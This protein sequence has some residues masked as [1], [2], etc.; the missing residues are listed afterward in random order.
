[1]RGD[2]LEEMTMKTLADFKRR[3]QV[4]TRLLCVAN[5]Y[6]PNVNGTVREVIEARTVGFISK[7]DGCDRFSTK[8]PKANDFRV[9]DADTVEWKLFPDDDGTVTLRFVGADAVG[10]PYKMAERVEPAPVPAHAAKHT[11]GPWEA[12]DHST[13]DVRDGAI[14]AATADHWNVASLWAHTHGRPIEEVDANA[15]LIA[16]A[17]EMFEE[18]LWVV[19][20]FGT[21]DPRGLAELKEHVGRLSAVL[22]KAGA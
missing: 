3:V 20:L 17:P 15:R 13:D 10:K 16:A 22:T 4:G 5:T 9:V 14:V 6:S 12:L 8:Y 19:R 7:M 18:A 21:T 2:N 1:V 11:P